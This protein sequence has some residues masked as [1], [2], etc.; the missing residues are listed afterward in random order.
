MVVVNGDDTQ[1]GEEG[2][3]FDETVTPH[4]E[5]GEPRPDSNESRLS[6]LKHGEKSMS[7]LFTI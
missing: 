7:N 3:S 1:A 5:P 4:K 6:R 2:D